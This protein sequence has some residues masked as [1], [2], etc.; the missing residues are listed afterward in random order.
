[1]GSTGLTAVVAGSSTLTELESSG[2][3]KRVR[4]PL[5]SVTV[6]RLGDL[7]RWAGSN[8][9]AARADLAGPEAEAVRNIDGIAMQHVEGK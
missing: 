4:E 6:L 1:M 8:G 5:G 3:R 9:S 2:E 7:V